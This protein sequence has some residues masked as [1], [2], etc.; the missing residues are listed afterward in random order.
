MFDRDKNMHY[1][2]SKDIFIQ[3]K[4]VAYGNY[5]TISNISVVYNANNRNSIDIYST[6]SVNNSAYNKK[7]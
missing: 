2:R 1:Y 4:E 6:Y 7:Y 5:G 3:Q